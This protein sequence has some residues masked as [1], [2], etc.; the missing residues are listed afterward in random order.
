MVFAGKETGGIGF[1]TCGW[2]KDKF[3]LSWQVQPTILGEL[4][5]NPNNSQR[6]MQAFMQMKKFDIEKLKNA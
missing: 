4:M 1:L 2:R 5:S 6:V 3:G